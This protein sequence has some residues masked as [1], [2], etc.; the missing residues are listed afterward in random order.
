MNIYQKLLPGVSDLV[1]NERSFERLKRC[2][3]DKAPCLLYG[4]PG[5]GKTSGV[6]AIARGLGYRV[7]EVN[8]SDE[9]NKEQLKNILS[10]VKMKGLGQKLIFLLDEVDGLREGKMVAKILSEARH[11]VVLTANELHKVPDPVKEKC[12]L[13]RFYEPQLLEV[14]KRAKQLA[15]RLGKRA[16]YDKVTR[17]IR[18][19]INAA[20]FGSENYKPENDFVR[21]E[22]VFRHKPFRF[23]RDLLIWLM[24]NAPRFYYAKQ[25]FEVIQVICLA[26]L[27]GYPDLLKCIPKGKRKSA[28]Y[29]YYLKRIK[30]LRGE[31]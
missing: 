14:L 17:D 6:Y 21:V 27:T 5:V 3:K 7:I 29:P 1:G 16:R 9:R 19:S 31:G 22:A 28:T 25:L 4:A 2:I 24:D 30:V 10:R 26:D 15:E 12:I 20:L 13:I 8:A 18:S 23:D 11:S